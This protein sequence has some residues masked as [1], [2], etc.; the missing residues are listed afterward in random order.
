MMHEPKLAHHGLEEGDLLV[1][2]GVLHLQ[3]DGDVRFDRDCGERVVVDGRMTQVK[4]TPR[5]ID[6]RRGRCTTEGARRRAGRRRCRG[7]SGSGAR[8]RGRA[9]EVGG[10]VRWMRRP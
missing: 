2:I 5:W 9:E 1:E 6:E 4:R 7:G 8:E 10:A 3:G